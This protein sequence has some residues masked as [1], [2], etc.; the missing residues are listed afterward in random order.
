[1]IFWKIENLKKRLS[2]KPLSQKESFYYL[3]AYI[4]FRL[5][6]STFSGA[7]YGFADTFVGIMHIIMVG[8]GLLLCY[9]TNGGEKGNNF[10]EKYISISF[11]MSVRYFAFMYIPYVLLD[12]FFVARPVYW[13][14]FEFIYWLFFLNKKYENFKVF[15]VQSKNVLVN[16]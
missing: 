5:L 1:M 10:L 14:V 11:V 4:G 3:C 12:D 8:L 6:M 9:E 2:S 16:K 13:I 15:E 7:S